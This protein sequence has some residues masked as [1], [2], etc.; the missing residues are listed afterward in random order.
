MDDL[1]IYSIYD[2]CI[3]TGLIYGENPPAV[4][5]DWNA[6]WPALTQVAARPEPYRVCLSLLD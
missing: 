4:G 1:Y 2:N 6:L 5:F 3:T